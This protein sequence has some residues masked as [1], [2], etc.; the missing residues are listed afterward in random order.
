MEIKCSVQV[1]SFMP[2]GTTHCQNFP[3]SSCVAEDYAV[4]ADKLLNEFWFCRD[5]NRKEEGRGI[6]WENITERDAAAPELKCLSVFF[7]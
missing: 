2:R 5:G 4:G 1:H 6:K 7:G 3:A